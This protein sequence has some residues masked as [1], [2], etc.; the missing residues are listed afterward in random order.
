MVALKQSYCIRP[1][2]ED[3]SLLSFDAVFG[4]SFLFCVLGFED[5]GNSIA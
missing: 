2:V 5:E 4:S 1:V 3:S